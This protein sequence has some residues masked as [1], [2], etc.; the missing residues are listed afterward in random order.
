M[1]TLGKNCGMPCNV[2]ASSVPAAR[3]NAT[4]ASI[5]PRSKKTR[6]LSERI[7][8]RSSHAK[9]TARRAKASISTHGKA[10]PLCAS[11][12]RTIRLPGSRT[13]C[14]S[15][16]LKASIRVDFPPPEQPE[17][18]IR[19]SDL[20]P[21]SPHWSAPPRSRHRARSRSSVRFEPV[22]P[23]RSASAPPSC[24]IPIRAAIWP[25]NWPIAGRA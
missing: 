18:I 7:F 4:A 6:P 5:R 8:R 9:L 21:R 22:F 3:F 17:M 12:W 2:S 1:N 16:D 25:T 11:S 24:L 13:T 20:T 14:S 15:S 23:S 10:S 19:R